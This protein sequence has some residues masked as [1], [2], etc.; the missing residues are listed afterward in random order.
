MSADEVDKVIINFINND[1]EHITNSKAEVDEI[2]QINHAEASIIQTALYECSHQ[3]IEVE[4][5]KI[6]IG[7]EQRGGVN[8]M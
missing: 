6:G 3:L 5:E 2:E 1:T 4:E 7:I 8:I